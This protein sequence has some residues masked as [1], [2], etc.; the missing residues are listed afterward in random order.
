MGTG[1]AVIVDWRL[2]GPDSGNN[3]P[4]YMI[5]DPKK[6]PSVEEA[7]QILK[8]IQIERHLGGNHVVQAHH[9]PLLV[10]LLCITLLGPLGLYL[11]WRDS[12]K[13]TGKP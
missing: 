4:S 2:K 12:E 13:R 8:D 5:R 11:L 7:K 3:V 6:W 1:N 10:S 9:T